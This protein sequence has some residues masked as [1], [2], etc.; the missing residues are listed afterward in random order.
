MTF[1]GSPKKKFV[2]GNLHHAFPPDDKW[3]TPKFGGVNQET[4]DRLILTIFSQF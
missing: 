4:L 3:S 1:R 2:L